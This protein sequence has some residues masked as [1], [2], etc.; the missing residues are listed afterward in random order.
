MLVNNG[1]EVGGGKLLECDSCYIWIAMYGDCKINGSDDQE[2]DHMEI[3]LMSWSLNPLWCTC[4]WH[5]I[6]YNHGWLLLRNGW[7][8][9]NKIVGKCIPY[10]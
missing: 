5:Y 1:G 7:S 8:T 3:Y 2:L 4:K 10:F 6:L 9:S